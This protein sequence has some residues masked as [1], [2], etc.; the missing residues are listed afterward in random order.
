M[1]HNMYIHKTHKVNKALLHANQCTL[2]FFP[3]LIA[4][5]INFSCKPLLQFCADL[6]IWDKM[7]PVSLCPSSIISNSFC[8]M[9]TCWKWTD[10]HIHTHAQTHAVTH[11]HRQADVS[12]SVL[13]D[14]CPLPNC[15][16][17]KSA[18]CGCQAV[19]KRMPS[20]CCDSRSWPSCNCRD[21][22]ISP[23]HLVCTSVP[24]Q[25]HWQPEHTTELKPTHQN[26]SRF[27]VTGP[28]E[29]YFSKCHFL[30]RNLQLEVI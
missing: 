16:F 3:K 22:A 23:A 14:T 20:G 13:T 15:R 5:H 1:A 8:D 30:F 7:S 21:D 9:H 27:I 25:N 6:D 19:S 17:M 29:V 10:E 2:L 11:T 4:R 24:A 12:Q 26:E 18:G 28:S